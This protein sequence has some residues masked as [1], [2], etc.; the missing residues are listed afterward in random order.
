[1]KKTETRK[2]STDAEMLLLSLPPV[3]A[4]A[5][6]KARGVTA[7]KPNGKQS[8]TQF[9]ITVLAAAVGIENYQPRKRGRP[10]TKSP[11]E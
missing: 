5:I 7:K 4:A 11:S 2:P 1:M 10:A 3:L 9:A 6:D 8:R